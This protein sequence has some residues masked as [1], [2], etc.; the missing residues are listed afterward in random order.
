MINLILA[1]SVFCNVGGPLENYKCQHELISCLHKKKAIRKD[2]DSYY[3]A[4]R[5]SKNAVY[6]CFDKIRIKQEKLFAL[7]VK[8]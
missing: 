8:K 1:I 2:N 6:E 7:K 4:K 3:V 5:A